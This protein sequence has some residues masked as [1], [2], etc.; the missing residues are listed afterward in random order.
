MRHQRQKSKTNQHSSQ[1]DNLAKCRGKMH[2]VI[3]TA[4]TPLSFLRGS[5]STRSTK[6][7]RHFKSLLLDLSISNV[8]WASSF[9][10]KYIWK[11]LQFWSTTMYVL[12]CQAHS[13]LVE[14]ILHFSDFSHGMIFSANNNTTHHDMV[15]VFCQ[16]IT[17]LVRTKC[18]R[19][20]FFI[21]TSNERFLQ[22]RF[23]LLRSK[24]ISIPPTFA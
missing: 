23:F 8:Y 9:K 21:L 1:N 3:S 10:D 18:M 13:R 24:Y 14:K 12:M 15:I 7:S 5:L 6:C 16:K 2:Q 22:Q 4:S 11:E 19:A 20:S 17:H